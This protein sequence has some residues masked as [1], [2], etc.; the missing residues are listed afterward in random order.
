MKG[1]K[2]KMFVIFGWE[3]TAKPIESVLKAECFHCKN[4]S[5]W[6]VWKETE[7]I[8]LF[9]IKLIPFLNKYYL[10]CSI[11]NDSISLPNSLAREILNPNNRT[12][13]LHDSLVKSIEKHQ[14]EGMTET[15]IEYWKSKFANKFNA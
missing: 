3:K 5:G 1:D 2:E 6:D 13:E 12:T 8:S 9:F 7:W 11:C 4:L 15:Q 10:V 14:F